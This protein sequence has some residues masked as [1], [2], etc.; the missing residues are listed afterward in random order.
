MRPKL[1][2]AARSG[3]LLEM[4]YLSEQGEISQRKVKVLAVYPKSFRAFC[5]LRGDQRVF[6]LENVLSM[7]P[8]RRG[9]RRGA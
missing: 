4:I 6:K 8:V 7:R 5:R 1:L 2:E 3:E 9:W